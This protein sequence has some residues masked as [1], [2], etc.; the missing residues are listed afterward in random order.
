WRAERGHVRRTGRIKDIT[1]PGGV[2]FNPFD[3][4][5]LIDRH[6]AVLQCAIVPMHDKVLGERACCFATIKPGATL[7][8]ADVT[9]WLAQHQVAKL[10]WPERLEITAAMPLTPTR[11]IIKGELMKKLAAT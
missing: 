1:K 9:A 6:P 4:E 5:A 7:T 10:K 8:L 2:K 11:K 3:V